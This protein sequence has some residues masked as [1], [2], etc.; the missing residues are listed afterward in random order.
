MIRGSSVL[1]LSR[2]TVPTPQVAGLVIACITG[3]AVS[4]TLIMM[5][6][7][8]LSH[9]Y[10]TSAW[11]MQTRQAMLTVTS[12]AN[13]L[14]GMQA[15]ARAIW[16][17]GAGQG[18]VSGAVPA[19]LGRSP[20]AKLDVPFEDQ[21]AAAIEKLPANAR[22][23]ARRLQDSVRVQRTALQ[24][25]AQLAAGGQ[26]QQALDLFK[27]PL[28]WEQITLLRDQR[29]IVTNMTSVGIAER[30][31]NEARWRGFAFWVVL[32]GGGLGFL[33]VLAATVAGMLG[34]ERRHAL[35]RML[36]RAQAALARS[37]RTRNAFLQVV[38]HDLR[39]PL[40]AI[41]LFATGLERRLP[42]ND[43]SQLL[44][45]MRSAAASMNRML[46]GLMD[47]SRLDA[48]ATAIEVTSL[49]L[50]ALLE[51]IRSEFSAIALS[52]GLD[53][54]IPECT[55]VVETDAIMLESILRNLVSNA[56]RYTRRGRVELACGIDE[57]HV[58]IT[59]A[60]TGIGIPEAD[61]DNIF[62]DFFTVAG[63]GRSAEGL[64]LGLGLVRRMTVLLGVSLKV[65]SSVGVGTR[66]SLTV[67]L[68][69]TVPVDL[70]PIFM[71]P[72]IAPPEQSLAGLRVLVVDDDEALRRLLH[73]ELQSRGMLVTTAAEPDEVC[74]MFE[75]GWVGGRRGYDADA[76]VFDVIL[77]DRDLQSTM[78]GPELLDHL[79]AR[80]GLALPA[81]ILSGR[82]TFA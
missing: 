8:A 36:A 23:P 81:L 62:Q 79:A 61:L 76:S 13:D 71:P 39:Q 75:R 33:A 68:S 31:T 19:D 28:S 16:E 57:D 11:M 2:P 20:L 73:E 69:R 49:R 70:V 55:L 82:P 42:N 9:A 25:G 30:T 44:E 4:A 72:V 17:R 35:E 12:A 66:F 27:G 56:V 24:L 53:F 67:P 48:G 54:D 34:L 3:I 47:V 14:L 1:K 26:A 32:L 7:S 18:D 74:E 6:V 58:V 59:V 38:G 80:F 37:E 63:S 64:G 65:T 77:M 22:P 29:N 46:S 60:D 21:V 52:K 10:D 51:P 45:G 5:S 78:T 41:G 15:D 43:S 50:E 40:Q